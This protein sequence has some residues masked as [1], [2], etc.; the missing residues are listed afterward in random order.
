MHWSRAR[1][2]RSSS[3]TAIRDPRS[4]EAPP[5]RLTFPEGL[6]ARLVGTKTGRVANAPHF[7]YADATYKVD[8][9]ERKLGLNRRVIL[10]DLGGSRRQEIPVVWNRLNYLSS[11]PDRVTLGGS[12]VR[13]F[14]RCPDQSV[15]LLKV[16]SAPAG[17]KAVVSSERELTVSLDPDAPG[18][19]DGM[20]EVATSAQ[21]QDPLRIPVVRYAPK[22]D[23]KVAAQ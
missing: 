18:V 23:G 6:E 11:A 19:I 5:A 3:F 8:L 17:I 13:V 1:G 4:P 16:L 21:G 15:E 2:R 12:P 14:L 20:I 22:L 10:A 9:L 7:T